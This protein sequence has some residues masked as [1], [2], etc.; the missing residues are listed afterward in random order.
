MST[1][2]GQPEPSRFE[3]AEA[4]SQ[5]LKAKLAALVDE[6]FTPK[7][8]Q[9]AAA[10][11]EASPANLGESPEA[12]EAPL[13]PE[14]AAVSAELKED[15][16]ATTPAPEALAAP[17]A[18]LEADP[19]SKEA[20]LRINAIYQISPPDEIAAFL[21]DDE[22][23]T[24][25]QKVSA[26]GS[27]PAAVIPIAQQLFC[28]LPQI[29]QSQREAVS[30][31]ISCGFINFN[32]SYVQ[33]NCGQE[34]SVLSS[35]NVS[36]E[37][38]IDFLKKGFL[39]NAD[40]FYHRKFDNFQKMA[41]LQDANSSFLSSYALLRLFRRGQLKN[42]FTA[43]GSRRS[44]DE[45]FAEI[46]GA[47]FKG[48]LNMVYLQNGKLK[49]FKKDEKG[50]LTFELSPE[51]SALVFAECQA[52]CLELLPTINYIFAR[53][54]RKADSH[55]E[56]NIHSLLSN[57]HLSGLRKNSRG[58]IE[59]TAKNGEATA[60]TAGASALGKLWH[61]KGQEDKVQEEDEAQK[62]QELK[63]LRYKIFGNN[64]N[65]K[66]EGSNVVYDDECTESGL[67][68][69]DHYLKEGRRRPATLPLLRALVAKVNKNIGT[70]R[71]LPTEAEWIKI[72]TQISNSQE[73]L[74][75]LNQIAAIKKL[76]SDLADPDKWVKK[77][78][79]GKAP[80]RREA[81]LDL[82]NKIIELDR[83]QTTFR[84]Y[85]TTSSPLSEFL[86]T[87]K[88][89][90]ESTFSY[91]EKKFFPEDIDISENAN[92]LTLESD[93]IRDVRAKLESANNA[94]IE[95]TRKLVSA[96]KVFSADLA[97]AEAKG[98]AVSERQKQGTTLP[99]NIDAIL[100]RVA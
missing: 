38:K 59:S 95:S 31:G 52:I 44:G 74:A 69:I 7:E 35:D 34:S 60:T 46:A 76:Q 68:N 70:I 42:A 6:G 65:A 66:I 37:A 100:G 87:S 61:K 50:A 36:I 72:K 12:A 8:I 43:E 73:Y 20:I 81:E 4:R 24:C 32:S 94:I 28:A 88:Y 78:W 99:E 5:A 40:A 62:Q 14:I 1:T 92:I 2:P 91:S 75:L 97:D 18:P 19:F 26:S 82:N 27:I 47:D 11:M 10:T 30:A 41:V 17:E 84:K 55:S 39:P 71:K 53:Q 80:D 90:N 58:E 86:S 63:V 25:Y 83:I 49:V 98:V 51:I 54:N 22:Y 15:L 48:R 93:L 29:P 96:H 56:I 16:A 89:Y 85:I 21:E 3:S 79:F 77:G 57:S 23:L 13:A 9:D 67:V 45:L 33:T 64:K